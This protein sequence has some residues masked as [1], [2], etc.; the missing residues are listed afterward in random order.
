M[1][2][3]LFPLLAHEQVALMWVDFNT[4]IV[5]DN[6]YKYAT[7]EDQKVYT[8]FVDVKEALNFA[9]TAI[10]EMKSIECTIYDK[11]QKVVLHSLVLYL[12]FHK[13]GTDEQ[14]AVCFWIYISYCKTVRPPLK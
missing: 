11:N 5:L 4:G 14:A 9:K 10:L 6:L 1:A 3:E 7:R 13:D 8:I 12:C 2:I